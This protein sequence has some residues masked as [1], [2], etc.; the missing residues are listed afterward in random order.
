MVD[1]EQDVT[2]RLAQAGITPLIGGLVPE[3]ATAD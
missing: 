1:V 3:P 2:E